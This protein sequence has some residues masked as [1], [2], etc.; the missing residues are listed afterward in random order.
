[1]WYI[2]IVALMRCQGIYKKFI[3]NSKTL[4]D[5]HHRMRVACIALEQV[6]GWKKHIKERPDDLWILDKLELMKTEVCIETWEA[7]CDLVEAI[8][9]VGK[10][11]CKNRWFASNNFLTYLSLPILEPLND[12]VCPKVHLEEVEKQFDHRKELIQQ[13]S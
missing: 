12:A 7:M 8:V 4:E 11:V 9:N 2:C 13:T 6:R 1:M 3:K 5:H 10:K